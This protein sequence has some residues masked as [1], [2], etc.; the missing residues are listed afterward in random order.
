M[1]VS[2]KLLDT[3]RGVTE[4][5]A[6]AEKGKST[7]AS[8]ASS[9]RMWTDFPGRDL[10]ASAELSRRFGYWSVDHI[11][12]PGAH[13]LG[14]N[15]RSHAALVAIALVSLSSSYRPRH[16]IRSQENATDPWRRSNFGIAHS[17]ESLC[18]VSAH[19]RCSGVLHDQP[20][21]IPVRTSSS[22]IFAVQ[23]REIA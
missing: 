22:F 20:A 11:L 17:T 9:A 4:M 23:V 7:A 5:V 18:H 2:P 10:S 14:I 16:S 12:A 3:H 6:E 1:L 19:Q 15:R 8:V 21:E 13:P